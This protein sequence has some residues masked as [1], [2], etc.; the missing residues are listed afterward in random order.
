MGKIRILFNAWADQEVYSAQDLNARELALRLDPDR[1]EISF[2]QR[3]APDPRLLECSHIRRLP[4]P[5]RF[6]APRMVR[7]MLASYDVMFYVRF[8]RADRIFRRLGRRFGGPRGLVVPVE[9]QLDQFDTDHYSPEVRSFYRDIARL[10]DVLVANSPYV[11]KTFEDRFDRRPDVIV[12]G[13][14]SS[15]FRR[16]AKEAKQGQEEPK[17]RGNGR[18]QVLFAGGLLPRKHP[19]LVLE[20]AAQFPEADFS[21]IGEGPMRPELEARLAR[22]D[23]PNARLEPASTFE[24]YARR[25]VRADIFLFPSRLEGLPRVTL[26]AAAAGIPEI[27][28]D[29]YQAPSVVDGLN[30]FQV[31]TFP[32]MLERLGTLIANPELCQKMGQAGTRHVEQYDWQV[33]VERWQKI[34]EDVAAGRRLRGGR[35]SENGR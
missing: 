14:E 35:G 26:E 13:I 31:K 24:D 10:A 2:F 33:A 23:L 27:L 1:F 11:G 18:V 7:H 21:V 20:A 19:E 8:Q 16:L 32:E 28:F 29:D 22:G 34:F 17:H 6:G 15:Y 9:S 5:G 30:G 3:G 4:L 12:N 25:L